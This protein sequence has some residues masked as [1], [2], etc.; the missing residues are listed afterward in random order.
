MSPFRAVRH[1]ANAAN[2][3]RFGRIDQKT[4]HHYISRRR[5]KVRMPCFKV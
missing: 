1:A 3:Y 2:T 4:V 5:R